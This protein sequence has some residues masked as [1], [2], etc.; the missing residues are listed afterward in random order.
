MDDVVGWPD[1]ESGSDAIH[2]L[3]IS[4]YLNLETVITQQMFAERIMKLF[5]HAFTAWGESKDGGTEAFQEE[6]KK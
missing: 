1:I 3:L 6:R 4:V 5:L 2:I